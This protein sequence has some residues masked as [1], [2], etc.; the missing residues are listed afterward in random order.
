MAAGSKKARMPGV[1]ARWTLLILSLSFFV[2]Q[3]VRRISRILHANE[4]C[5]HCS[6]LQ[7]VE[8]SLR[9]PFDSLTL[10]TSP[11]QVLWLE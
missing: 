1:F 4:I 11:V 9:F 5:H 7:V 3:D 8:Q 10:S 6:V 2:D